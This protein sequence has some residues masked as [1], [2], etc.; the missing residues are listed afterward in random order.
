MHKVYVD[1]DAKKNPDGKWNAKVKVT[2]KFDFTE[3]VIPI[4]QGSL[5]NDFLWAANDAA[6]ISSGLGFLDLVKVEITYN[7]KY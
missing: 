2:D 4:N 3:L 5:K 6:T 7:Q 1:I